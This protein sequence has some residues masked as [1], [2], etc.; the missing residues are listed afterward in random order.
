M[1]R[2]LISL[3]TLSLCVSD[4]SKYA[5]TQTPK[6]IITAPVKDIQIDCRHSN[7]D[8][9]MIQW[10]KQTIGLTDL[11]LIAYAR[12][13]SLDVENTFKTLY[14]VSGS[15]SSRS[16]LH[17]LNVNT[18]TDSAVYFCTASSHSERKNSTTLT[19]TLCSL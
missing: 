7:S 1:F 8:F 3:V 14:E 2:V 11:T 19:K 10:Y 4:Q 13:T 6:D 5:V 16:S 9:D 15:G 17:V 18:T 12:F